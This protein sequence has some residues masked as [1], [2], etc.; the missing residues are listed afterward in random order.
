[1]HGCPCRRASSQGYFLAA[2]VNP[3]S[4]S[5]NT[6]AHFLDCSPRTEKNAAVRNCLGCSR[7]DWLARGLD[8]ADKSIRPYPA[9]RGKAPQLR[10]GWSVAPE[11]QYRTERWKGN[12]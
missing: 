11:A 12:L 2:T 7:V 3:S 4:S 5:P 6:G 8:P 9:N 10:S 1:L